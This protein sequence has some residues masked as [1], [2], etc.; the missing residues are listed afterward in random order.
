MSTPFNEYWLEMGAVV[1]VDIETTAILLNEI[2]RLRDET[3][4]RGGWPEKKQWR[5]LSKEKCWDIC[6]KHRNEPFSLLIATQNA[7]RELNGGGV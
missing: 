6:V 2:K 5:D 4:N 1:P 7:L 3:F